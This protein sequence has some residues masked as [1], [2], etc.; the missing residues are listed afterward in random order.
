MLQSCRTLMLSTHK[1]LNKGKTTQTSKQ[2]TKQTYSQQTI[3]KTT[4]PATTQPNKSLDKGTSFLPHHSIFIEG[5]GIK[6]FPLNTKTSVSS[7][8]LRR[9]GPRWVA[10]KLPLRI[11]RR[12]TS[13]LELRRLRWAWRHAAKRRD[14]K[15]RRFAQSTCKWKRARTQRQV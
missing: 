14:M 2:P 9:L 12:R 11:C 6:C 7:W 3:K 13:S 15:Q 5:S 10:Q 1:G 8:R 4:N